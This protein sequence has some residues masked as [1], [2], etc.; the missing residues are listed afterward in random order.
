MK[1]FWTGK[2]VLVT[3]HTGFKGSWLC[4]WLNNLGADVIGY[5]LQ[6]PTTPNM[7]SITKLEKNVTSIIGDI[8]NIELLKKVLLNY[9]PEIIFH[10]AAQPIVSESYKYPLETFKTNILGTANILYL[11][12][13]T[14]SV[15]VVVNIT[16]DKCY[17]NKEWLWSYREND[18]IGGLDPYS[19][20]KS[21]SELLTNCFRESFY[22][23]ND[24]FLASA[25][26]GNVIGGGDFAKDRIVPDIVNSLSNNTLPILRHPYAIRPW[27]HVLEPL[28]GYLLLAEK[29]LLEGFNYA[30]CWNFGPPE[31]HII[32]VLDLAK[33]LTA[34]FGVTDKAIFN[35]TA[36]S[37]FHEALLLK[38]DSS[39]S[40]C[41]LDWHTKLNIDQTLEWT[42]QWYKAY[43]NKCDMNTFS[44]KQINE[45]SALS[46]RYHC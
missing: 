18:T 26:A 35:T 19:C 7:F 12:F 44:L 38:L 5:S 34:L 16:S 39:K 27:Q 36:N 20:S 3:G 9:K 31:D 15:K 14:D 29:M 13:N 6:P 25:R 21:C 30:D 32:N 40:N 23:K 2:K 22:N 10:L 11:A 46:H 1:N 42:A 45:Y 17:K 41:K 33:K 43:F 37:S 28:Y 4:L 24:K 8:N